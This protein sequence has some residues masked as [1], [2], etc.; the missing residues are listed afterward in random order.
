MGDWRGLLAERR[1]LLSDGAWG[2]ELVRRGL[3]PG[4]APE[5]LNLGQPGLVR[6]VA[7]SYVEAGSDIILTNTFG[8]SRPKLERAGLGERLAEVNRRAVEISKEAA[9]DRALV[10]ASVGPTGEFMEPLGPATEE[11]MR[12]VFAEQISALAQGGADGI[13]IETMTDLGE[14]TAAVAAARTACELPVAACLTFDKGARGYATMMGVTPSQAA[15]ELAAAGADL[16]G[17]NCGRGPADLVEIARIL[18]QNTDLPL[19]IKPNA[20]LPQLVNGETVYAQTPE[21]MA[22]YL[23]QLVAA[24]ASVIGG[25]CGSTP[26][27]IRRLAQARERL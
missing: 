7:A 26:E 18:R 10:F 13:V 12:V 2:T 24:G 14:A 1:V 23:P 5:R 6:A 22:G 16:V 20:G 15:N 27:H 19:W 8:G 3:E 4:E 9:G 17:S 25:C 21:E 11:E